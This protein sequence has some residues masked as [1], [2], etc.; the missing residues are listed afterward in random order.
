[1]KKITTLLAALTILLT[2]QAES[3]EKISYQAIIRNTKGELIV[4]RTIGVKISILQETASGTVV[5]VETHLP[6]SN[7]NG[8]VNIEVGGGTP[9]TGKFDDIEWA[10]GPYFI[11]TEMDTEGGKAYSIVAVSQLLSV[12]YALYAKTT[13]SIPDNSVTS[14]KI[15]DGSVGTADLAPN[16]VTSPKI[17]DGTI[18]T[19]DIADGAVT[20]A[21]LPAG[22]T[23]TTYLRGDGI[24]A[25]PTGSGGTSQW[26]TSGN[27]IY[28]NTGRVGIGTANPTAYLHVKGTGAG[29]GSLLAE[30]LFKEK[31][32]APP[33]TGAGTRMM[34]YSDKA[35]FRAGEVAG[36]NWDKDSVGNH[37][38][39]MG[40][41]TRAKGIASTAIG[42]LNRATGNY[43]LAL[44]AASEAS[45]TRSVA[46]G[47][48]NNATNNWSMAL[49]S[50]CTA[51][52]L[53]STAL[54]YMNTAAGDRSM[55]MGENTTA[56]SMSETV[57]GNN[58]S[59]Y[60]PVSKTAWNPADRLFVIGNG[61]DGTA[62]NAVTVLKNGNTG[63]GI[64]TPQALL[65][66][67]G[68]LR[69]TG[70]VY[71]EGYNDQVLDQFGDLP[72][73]GVE[74]H[75]RFLWYPDKSA[76]RAGVFSRTIWHKDSI[77]EFSLAMG[78]QAKATRR[79]ATSIGWGTIASGEYATA[80]GRGSTIASGDYSTAIGWGAK[81]IGSYA[82]AVGNSATASGY[83]SKTFGYGVTAPS[84][85]ETVIGL[86]NMDYTPLSMGA[87]SWNEGDRLFVVGNGKDASNK[88]NA[89][90]IL[91][92]GNMTVGGDLQVN[93]DINVIGKV[94]GESVIAEVVRVREGKGILR[95]TDG[96]QRKMQTFSV[97]VNLTIASGSTV[98]IDF[99]FPEVFG[100]SPAVWVGNVIWGGGGFAELVMSV[101]QITDGKG[102]LFI[103]NPK[104]SS[105]SPNFT[106]NII[107]MGAE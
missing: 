40:F 78:L 54:G 21:K 23:A 74:S 106:V 15:T 9:V 44:G 10:K 55:A 53:L 59:A 102:K 70:N 101:G 69:G 3:P 58:N 99:T 67:N 65:H 83:H 17:A 80:I 5:Y 25:T 68:P 33:V 4:N 97:P 32:D 24:W 49:G 64:D 43:S 16:S 13:G 11:K 90:T 77:G 94:K 82:I 36:T 91:K 48:G 73:I 45:G 92:N 20:I 27:N 31:Q 71:F 62:H 47:A 26:I 29:G 95:F 6:Q 46:I 98:S 1:M 76:L 8:L 107:A 50:Y 41:D 104:S 60:T 57:V 28:Y 93:S 79:Y 89:L 87:G 75:A 35:A 105:Q 96:N 12:P 37:S 66:T 42:N 19:A 22:A 34:W 103:Y 63:I 85:G 2:L 30:G 100:A 88:S 18:T 72:P 86:F 84:Y 14:T 38:V 52:G 61:G 56:Y 51:S 81:A 7:E 39:A